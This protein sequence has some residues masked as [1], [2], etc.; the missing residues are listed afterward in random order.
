MVKPV[1]TNARLPVGGWIAGAVVCWMLSLYVYLTGDPTHILITGRFSETP[2]DPD[3]VVWTFL[4]F[5][6]AL[7]CIAGFKRYLLPR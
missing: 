3:R 4:L 7:L 1:S 6:I 5:G 2:I